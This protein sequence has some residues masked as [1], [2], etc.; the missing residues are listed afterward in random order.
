MLTAIGGQSPDLAAL[1][2]G[3][4]FAPRCAR[5]EA[6]CSDEAP[7]LVSDGNARHRYACWFPCAVGATA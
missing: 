3:C 2:D 5:A 4:S 7:T 6:R 1:P